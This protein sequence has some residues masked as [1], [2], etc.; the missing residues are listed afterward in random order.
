MLASSVLDNVSEFQVATRSTLQL[1]TD[2][3]QRKIARIWIGQNLDLQWCMRN[4]AG[5][6]PS[7]AVY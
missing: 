1:A 7:R 5:F 2:S 3:W 6:L 4:F